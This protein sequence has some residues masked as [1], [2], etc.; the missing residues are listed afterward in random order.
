VGR[1]TNKQRRVQQSAGARERAAAARAEQKRIEQRKRAMTIL[2]SVVA[3]AVVV[4]AIA[5]YAIFHKS[6]KTSTA[7]GNRAVAT[8]AVIHDVSAVPVS[9]LN[10]VGVGPV[11]TYPTKVTGQP[12][13]TA[14]GKP[15][16]LF[17]GA[18]FC[19]YCA[20]ERWSMGVALSRFGTF[21]GYDTVSSSVTDVDPSTPSL[22]FDKYKYTSKYLTFT[23]VENEDRDG[24]PLQ[25]TTAAQTK[26]WATVGGSQSFPFVDFA[27]KYK[28]TGP[29]FDP[30]L[31]KG[32]SQSQIA[33]QL[34]NPK[35]K[36]S[37]A[38]NGAANVITAAIC[39]MTNNQ[40]STVCTSTITSLQSKFSG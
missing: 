4:I 10:T 29:S 1:T 9:T 36:V 19:P 24:K 30:A 14:S 8:A 18:E 26:T 7:S 15:E 31:L 5:G 37:Q 38:I 34:A 2:A 6:S 28:I 22:D 40:P 16:M 3:V 23:A 39:G 32:L 17:I 35:S 11:V 25:K 12:P 21:N 33:S 13:L 27:N 20:A